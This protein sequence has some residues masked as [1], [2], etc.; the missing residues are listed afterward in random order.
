MMLRRALASLFVFCLLAIPWSPANAQDQNNRYFPETGHNVQGDFL[1][2]YN[3]VSDPTTLYGYP[4]TE[5]F[6]RKDGLL[7]QYFQRARFEYHPELPDGQHVTLADLGTQMYMPSAQLNLYNPFACHLYAQTNF[8]VCFAFLDFYNKYG[9]PLQFGYPISPFEYHDGLI[10]QY[11]QRARME[12][13]PSNP[14]GERVVLTDLGSLYFDKL[15]ED[16]GLR[17]PVQPLNASIQ[18]LITSLQVRAFVWKAVTVG[19][20]QQTIFIVADDQSGRP[21]NNASCTAAIHWINESAQVI[22]AAT[23]SSGIAII[24]FSFTN[25]PLGS[26]IPIDINC[27][28]QNL[29]G[30]STASFRIWY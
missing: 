6:N 7:I 21:F 29:N 19:S 3:V 1:R 18:P 17:D 22:S 30:S 15:N 13:Q 26:L 12:W 10:V 16:P 24:Q 5:Q 14:E 9:G 28:N 11:F 27:S 4:I 2:F 23:N 20:D 8:P 25:K